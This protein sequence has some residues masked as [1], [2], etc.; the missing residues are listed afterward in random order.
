MARPDQPTAPF[1]LVQP[2]Q[3]RSLTDV[4]HK[5]LREAITCGSLKPGVRLREV[6]LAKRYNV[7]ATPVR[8]ALRRLER[9]GLVE[10][11]PHRGATVAAI[12]AADLC[13]LYEVHE[14]LEA[15]AVRRAAEIHGHDLSLAEQL[16][17]QLDACVADPDQTTF[18]ALDLHFHRSLNMLSG[19]AQLADL[20]SQTHRRIQAARN[21]HEIHLPDRPRLS[22]SQHRAL[23]RAIAAGNADEA[24]ELARNQIRSVREP[25]LRMLAMARAGVATDEVVVDHP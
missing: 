3:Q 5:E 13:N 25:V 20:I 1:N 24:E 17:D 23:L 4:V 11:H 14:V 2:D 7:S 8:E 19:N 16:L 22:Q 15:F 6:A 12:S 21:K 10:T 18:N 9:E